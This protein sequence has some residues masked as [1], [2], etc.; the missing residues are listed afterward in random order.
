MIISFDRDNMSNDIIC[1]SILLLLTSFRKATVV[2]SI[3]PCNEF[4]PQ[5]VQIICSVLLYQPYIELV[6][7]IEISLKIEALL[8]CLKGTETFIIHVLFYANRHKNIL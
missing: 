5:V 2:D 6:Y 3:A 8:Y 7:N 1:K 4:L